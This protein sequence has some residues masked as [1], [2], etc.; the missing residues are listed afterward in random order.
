MSSSNVILPLTSVA[1]LYNYLDIADTAT[2]Q[3]KELMEMSNEDIEFLVSKLNSGRNSF[4]ENAESKFIQTPKSQYSVLTEQ[5]S[6]RRKENVRSSR[7]E[8]NAGDN[9]QSTIIRLNDKM[10]GTVEV[11]TDV[12]IEDINKWQK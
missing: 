10:S 1:K 6:E 4:V 2:E 5:K 12:S 9:L 11:Q 8:S 7:T 3:K